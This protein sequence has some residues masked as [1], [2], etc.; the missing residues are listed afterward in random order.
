MSG[1]SDNDTTMARKISALKR[2]ID[3]SLMELTE[4][5]VAIN[6][7]RYP[8]PVEN[9]EL[10]R[11]RLLLTNLIVGMDAELKQFQA[12]SPGAP[13]IRRRFGPGQMRST[14]EEDAREKPDF[15]PKDRS[16]HVWEHWSL[17]IQGDAE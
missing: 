14:P 7:R 3:K 17:A 11:K 15:A 5:E 9:G 4:V 10:E 12:Q 6:A 1:V 2:A 16:Q 8:R 13:D